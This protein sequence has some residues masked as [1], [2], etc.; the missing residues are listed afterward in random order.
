MERSSDSRVSV[1]LKAAALLLLTFWAGATAGVLGDRLV[2][3]RQKRL[4]PKEGLQFVTNRAI[5]QMDRR[6]DL[7]DEQERR[8]R[9]IVSTHRTNIEALWTDVR[10]KVRSEMEAAE[11]EIRALL[12]EGQREQFD[13]LRAGWRRRAGW[14]TGSD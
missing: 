11:H 5:R 2:L 9:E 13:D 10:P 12:D 3:L 7:S 6:L 4:L 8:V 14:L 1:W